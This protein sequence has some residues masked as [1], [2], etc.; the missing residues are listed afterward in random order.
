MA[1]FRPSNLNKRLVGSPNVSPGNAG[2]IGPTKTP[3]IGKTPVALGSRYSSGSCPGVFRINESFCGVKESCSTPVCDYAGFF[4]C[5]GPSTTKWFIAPSC[6]E[7]CR[8]FN[9]ADAVTV[10]NACMGSCG[11]FIPTVDQL[12][13]A[14]YACR[15]YWDSYCTNDSYWSSSPAATGGPIPPG[16]GRYVHLSDG[17]APVVGAHYPFNPGT[18]SNLHWIR[19]FRCVT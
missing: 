1:I 10:A 11:W 3:Y 14:G 13:T 12:L 7:V 8:A 4:V 9:S 2:Q 15:S 18:T 19:V 17:C 6:T 16:L 5:C